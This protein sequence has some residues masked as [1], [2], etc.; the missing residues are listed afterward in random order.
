MDKRS[1][2]EAFGQPSALHAVYDSH[3]A[4]F[5]LDGET[6][7]YLRPDPAH[8]AEESLSWEDGSYPKVVASVSR[9]RAVPQWTSTPSP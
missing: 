3:M 4:S 5:T 6:Y 8:P 2:E 9:W 1:R 7:E